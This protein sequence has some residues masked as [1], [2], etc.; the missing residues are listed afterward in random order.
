MLGGRKFAVED[1]G[2]GAV[3]VDQRFQFVNFAGA[4]LG[5]RVGARTRL[6]LALHHARSGGGGERSQFLQR[7]FGVVTLGFDGGGDPLPLAGRQAQ[8]D[9]DR[10]FFC[11][12]GQRETLVVAF[13]S[14]GGARR[15][16]ARRDGGTAVRW[17][18]MERTG[19]YNR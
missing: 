5:G 18:V 11:C 16:V 1:D 12:H 15:H 10:D 14:G 2:V 17:P 7:F 6:N 19:H 8:A 13:I 4:H 3:Q 9:Q